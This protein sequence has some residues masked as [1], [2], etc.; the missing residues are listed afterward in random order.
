MSERREFT[1]KADWDPEAKVWYVA[2]SDVPGLATEADTIDQL[3]QKLRVMVPEML[4][5]NGLVPRDTTSVP[6]SFYAHVDGLPT[7]N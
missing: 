1:V 3:V 4:E 6:F 7:H 5:L 2:E